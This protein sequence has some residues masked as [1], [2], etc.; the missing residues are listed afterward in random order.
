MDSTSGCYSVDG[1]FPLR[2]VARILKEKILW[3]VGP[4]VDIT[5]GARDQEC[6]AVEN[7]DAVVTHRKAAFCAIGNLARLRSQPSHFLRANFQTAWRCLVALDAARYEQFGCSQKA[8]CCFCI[9]R[10][11]NSNG[12]TLL[13][14]N[15][16]FGPLLSISL[17]HIENRCHRDKEHQRSDQ[18]AKRVDG[19]KRKAAKIPQGSNSESRNSVT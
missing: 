10:N 17:N 4:G 16:E 14:S 15:V 8:C 9:A 19:T 6:R 13:A 7:A 1:E 3:L 11:S 2:Q 5:I 18:R 12:P